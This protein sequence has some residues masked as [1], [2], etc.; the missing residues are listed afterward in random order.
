MPHKSKGPTAFLCNFISIWVDF[1]HSG[2]KVGPKCIIG[3]D[4][5][6]F[7]A[8]FVQMAEKLPCGTAFGR[9][10]R[11]TGQKTC[12]LSTKAQVQ[13]KKCLEKTQDHTLLAKQC[14]ATFRGVFTTRTRDVPR[15]ARDTSCRYF[16]PKTNSNIFT[17]K[18]SWS[19]QSLCLTVAALASMK[20]LEGPWPR[21]CPSGARC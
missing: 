19:C 2:Q 21:F 4:L 1:R 7:D 3:C 5:L 15:R 8:E 14:S 18:P 12:D 16:C 17:R 6:S 20:V 10:A 9:V 11:P 13:Q